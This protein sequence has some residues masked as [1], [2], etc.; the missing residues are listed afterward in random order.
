M[1]L[2]VF[3]NISDSTGESAIVFWAFTPLYSIIC[4]L[5][6]VYFVVAA[7]AYTQNSRCA[8][9]VRIIFYL[10]SYINKKNERLFLLINYK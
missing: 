1:L 9:S 8:E 10:T 5:P 2:L 4:W 7:I 6:A 3:G